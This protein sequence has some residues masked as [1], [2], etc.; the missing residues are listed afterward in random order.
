MKG[1]SRAAV[2]GSVVEK[3]KSTGFIISSFFVQIGNNYE[4]SPPK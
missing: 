3:Y 1:I 2:F 4:N